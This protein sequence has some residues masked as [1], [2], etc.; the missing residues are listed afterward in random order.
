M[1]SYPSWSFNANSEYLQIGREYDD[2]IAL[3]I[4]ADRLSIPKLENL[5]IE[6]IIQISD[7]LNSIPIGSCQY[8]Y[9]NTAKDSLLRKFFVALIALQLNHEVYLK[10]KKGEFFEELLLDL[11]EFHT[12]R[13]GEPKEVITRKFFAS[14][15][16]KNGCK[17]SAT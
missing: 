11:V 7:R 12:R 4:L 14:V 5:V 8:I 15:E 16:E 3:W 9:N 17:D 13:R 10:A 2:L 1:A 6:K